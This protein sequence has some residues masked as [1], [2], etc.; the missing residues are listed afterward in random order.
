MNFLEI[1]KAYLTHTPWYVYLIF[2]YILFVGIKGLKGRT[3]HINKL[4]ILPIVFV[5]MSVDEMTNSISFSTVNAGVWL[6]G[7]LIGAYLLGWLPYQ[8]LRISADPKTKLLTIPGSWFTLVLLLVTFAVKYAI[9]VVLATHQEISAHSVY[10]LMI[11]SGV[12]TGAFVGRLIYGLRALS[13]AN[14]AAK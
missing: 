12:F 8:R 6:V 14:N 7:I 13:S 9:A 1:A 3:V 11:V 2:A 10:V 4:L 5:W